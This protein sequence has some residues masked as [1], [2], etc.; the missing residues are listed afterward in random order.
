MERTTALATVIG[1]APPVIAG[2]LAVAF[3]N[4]VLY[5]FGLGNRHLGRG[6]PPLEILPHCR[7]PI[8]DTESGAADKT[9]P[10]REAIAGTGEAKA[11]TATSISPGKRFVEDTGKHRPLP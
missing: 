2:L 1:A 3:P 8:A 7:P 5:L 9:G 11:S 6:P 10:N 4:L